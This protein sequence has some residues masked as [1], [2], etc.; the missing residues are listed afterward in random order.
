MSADPAGFELVNPMEEN[1]EGK[2]KPREGYSL[3]ETTNWY[4][5]VSNNPVK[6]IDPT[7]M[8]ELKLGFG[9]KAALKI[10]VYGD[11]NGTW[12]IDAAVG[13]GY[14]L[15]ATFDP[16]AIPDST[17]EIDKLS[18]EL[19]A[20]FELEGAGLKGS[21][22]IDNVAVTE[23]FQ[24]IDNEQ[25]LEISIAPAPGA[26]VTSKYHIASGEKETNISAA[27]GAGVDFMIFAGIGQDLDE[28]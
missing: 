21:M 23:N 2:L 18:T 27:T 14:G 25:S 17:G 9:F 5:Y 12:D 11:G 6:N 4:A 24:S 28:W 20:N 8:W 26:S 7:G 19:S 1:E 22:N 10:R 13:F 16:E 3:V 15:I